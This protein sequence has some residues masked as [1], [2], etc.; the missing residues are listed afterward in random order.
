[1]PCCPHLSRSL[2]LALCLALA[3]LPSA[4]SAAASRPG[5]L[6]LNSYHQGDEWADQELAGIMEVLHHAYPDQIPSIEH[7]DA[8]RFSG[9]EHRAG[10]RHYLRGKYRGRRPDL[11]LTLDNE[12]LDFLLAA[13]EDL[14]PGVPVVFAGVNGYHPAMLAGQPGV[15]GVAQAL[16][17]PGA[18]ETALRL[19]PATRGVLF[20]HDHT[21]SGRAMGEEALEA[22]ARF[23]DRL[24]IRD[25]PPLTMAGL[26]AML[27]ALPQGTVPIIL[28][29]VTDLAGQ[30]FT[31]EDSTRRICAASRAPVLGISGIRL[32]LGIL[33]GP[34]LTGQDHGRQAAKIALKVLAGQDPASIPVVPGSSR[35]L[36]D[37]REMTRFK[38]DESSLPPDSTVLFR[39]RS[40]FTEYRS[41]ML[42]GLSALGCFALLSLGLG[43]VASRL[44]RS[45]AELAES[46]ARFRGV[47]ERSPVGLLLYDD[48]GRVLQANQRT[49]EIFGAPSPESY[50]GVNL[51]ER[52]PAGPARDCLRRAMAGEDALF[53]GW[54]QAVVG[55]RKVYLGLRNVRLGPALRLALCE[56][57]TAQHLAE[58]ALRRSEQNYRDLFENSPVGIFLTDSTG[59]AHHVNPEMARILGADSPEDAIARYRDLAA[60]LYVDPERRREFIRLLREQ[61]MVENFEYE[62]NHARGGRIWLSMNARVREAR[63]DGSLLIDGFT[64]DIT[65]RKQ[66]ELA[67]A[68][69][70]TAIEEHRAKLA[71]A[72]ETAHMGHWE[73]DVASQVFFFNDQF[74]AL[75]GTTAAREGGLAMPAAEYARR[76]VHPDESGLVADEIS[77]VLAGGELGPAAIEH[78]IV[79]RDGEVR[80]MVVRYVVLRDRDGRPLKTIGANQ[81]IS[82]RKKVEDTLKFLVSEGG[83][84][85]FRSLA[86]FL[87]ATLD[88]DYICIDRLEGDQLT[89]TTLAVYFDGGFEKDITY[90]LADTP[91]G[92][93]VRDKTCVFTS[94][95]RH[96]FPRDAPLREMHAESYVGTVLWSS[97]GKPI[98]LIA[99]ISRK[100]L[101]DPALAE[102]IIRLAGVRASGELERR[103]AEAALFRAKEAAEAASRSKS[104][105]LATMSHE[106][107]TP[108]NGV[109]GMLQL[110]LTTDLDP[111]QREYVSTAIASGRSLLRVLS[112]ILDIS[113]IEAGALHIVV[114]DFRLEEV[115][116]PISMAF[117]NPAR[118]KGLHFV[119]AVDQGPPPVLRGDAGR[120][121]QVAYNLVGNAL[122]YTEDGEVRLEAYLLPSGDFPGV[123]RLHMAVSDTGIGVPEDKLATVFD[124]FTQVDGSFTRRHGGTGLGLAIVKRLVGLMGGELS[125]CSEPGVG[126]E[127]HV[128]LPL[129]LVAE[130]HPPL[131]KPRPSAPL[132][133][134]P[135]LRVLLAEDDAVNLLAISHMLAKFGHQVHSA[136]NGAEALRLLQEQDVD[137]V[138]MDIQM[139]GMDGREA[140]RRIRA[141]EAGETARRVPIVALT[142]HAMKGDREQFLADGMDGYL[143]KPVDMGELEQVLAA[144]ARRDA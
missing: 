1:M 18:V 141:G 2:L 96:L 116:E 126:T 91:C 34:L 59:Q 114:E 87:A 97:G 54:H 102:S 61:G 4:V 23:R 95:V 111:E 119:C 118:A 36:F 105:F 136:G 33:G 39:P 77:R 112:D 7:L 11:I 135:S 17:I 37:S 90:T 43:V 29:Y 142:A 60:T 127:V 71:L 139:P 42:V 107:R 10:F 138:L 84:E 128:S 63:P 48:S 76:F 15:T 49:A 69:S 130:P 133:D 28:T 56:D 9:P 99:A 104:E 73:M 82:E 66:S 38:V 35:L 52:L 14:F 47:F 131:E 109:L 6:I 123:I 70:Q 53:S 21:A 24:D 22:A 55:T 129:R 50:A 103:Q 20:I 121:R 65:T 93:V 132:R 94:G 108:L 58:E 62:A 45:R 41:Q 117:A 26:E 80:H 115:F 46:N 74:Y 88:M 30:V 57:L 101:E 72:L 92:Q 32:G 89:A 44:R 13:R 64:T 8:K 125:F 27:G 140:T 122:K 110:A 75:Y 137:C 98:G 100:P 106:I 134:V 78:R 83:E 40:I 120:I 85:F 143:A 86:Q 144:L 12:A 16:D 51:L 25:T 79:R 68:R 67:L 31:R 5:I 19:F 124:P 81:D 3:G 113:R